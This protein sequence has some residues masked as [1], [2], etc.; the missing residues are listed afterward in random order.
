MTHV[1]VAYHNIVLRSHVVGQ[2]VVYDQPQQSIKQG[3][4]HL[5]VDFIVLCLHEYHRLALGRVPYVCQVVQALAPLVHKKRRRF[6]VRWL[7]P[8]WEQTAFVGFVPQVLIK[9]S[10]GNLLEWFN[11]VNW[12]QVGVQIHEFDANFFE[13]AMAQK[14]SFDS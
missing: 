2:V 8:V 14:M 3:Q 5:F 12:D 13:T 9:V 1:F 6:A 4:V 10:I 7:N 11:V